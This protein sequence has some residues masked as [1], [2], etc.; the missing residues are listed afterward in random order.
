MGQTQAN[1]E[2]CKRETYLKPCKFESN[3]LSPPTSPSK[4][5]KVRQLKKFGTDKPHMKLAMAKVDNIKNIKELNSNEYKSKKSDSDEGK[6]ID[7]YI[8]LKVIGRGNFG[9]VMLVKSKIDNNFYALKCLKKVDVI[10]MKCEQLIRSE[11]RILEDIDHPFIIKL[12]LTFQTPEKLYMLFDYNNGG[13]LF[14]HLQNKIRFSEDVARFYAVQLYLALSY[15]H[16]NNI[17]YR[18]VK[19]ENIILDKEGYIKL[20]DFGLAKE[21]FY[22]DSLTGTLCGTSEYLG[23]NVI[24][25]APELVL[26]N[27]YGFGL[28]WWGFG[29][30]LYEMLIGVPPFTDENKTQLFKKIVT[31]EPTFKYFNDKVSISKEAKDLILKLLAKRPKDRIKPESISQHAFFKNIRFDDIHKRKVIAPFIPKIVSL[32]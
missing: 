23:N 18:D 11:K 24:K 32:V 25:L 16:Y 20:I 9:K 3:D 29:I 21:R 31:G 5:G 15:L 14:F 27:K 13:E 1:K 4:M 8:L 28:D 30:L 12:H 10:Q 7:D 6:S 19:P 2:P 17:I 26:G 22:N